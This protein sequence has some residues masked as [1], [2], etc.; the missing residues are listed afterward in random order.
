MADLKLLLGQEVAGTVS[1]STAGS[2]TFTYDSDYVGQDQPAAPVSVSMPTQVAVHSDKQI[3][4]WL[5]GL[6]PDSDAVLNRWAREFHVS[7]NSAFSL[8]STPLGED[9]PGAVRLVPPDRVESIQA[10]QLLAEGGSRR[11]RWPPRTSSSRRSSAS[12]TTI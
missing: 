4:P 1:R 2:L 5:W 12:T 11:V 7:A 9:C 8:L 6:L 10:D 3:A